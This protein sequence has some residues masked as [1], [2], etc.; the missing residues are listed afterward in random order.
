MTQHEWHEMT[1][2][3]DK[4]YNRARHFAN[5]WKFDTTLA[6]EEDWHEIE[7]P[8]REFLDGLRDILFRKYQRKRIPHRVL[9][10]ID[11]MLEDLPAEP[12]AEEVTGID[13][14]TEAE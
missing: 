7:T 12:D 5:R 10:D 1:P 11:V 14:T 4:R 6:S 3:G 8:D 13:S 2:D 9:N